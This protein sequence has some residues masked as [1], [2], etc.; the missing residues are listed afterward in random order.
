MQITSELLDYD[1]SNMRH[2]DGR[3]VFDAYIGKGDDQETIH[4]NVADFLEYCRET[5]LIHEDAHIGK[6]ISYIS[7]PVEIPGF[8][9]G[10][11]E[12]FSGYGQPRE[13]TF[14]EFL[15]D[16]FGNGLTEALVNYLND[17]RVCAESA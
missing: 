16:F 5:S 15:A 7:I 17:C 13:Y 10:R 8:D 14:A 2:I 6:S 9:A 4:V 12:C 3:L 11:D 1:H